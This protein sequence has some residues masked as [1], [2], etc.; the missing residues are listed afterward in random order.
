MVYVL[1]KNDALNCEIA[2]PDWSKVSYG[3]IPKATYPENGLYNR[4][5]NISVSLDCDC[6]QPSGNGGA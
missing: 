5:E 3:K 1:D 2:H 6:E 4:A